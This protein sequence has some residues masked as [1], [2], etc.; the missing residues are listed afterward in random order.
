MH[1]HLAAHPARRPV[2]PPRR[3]ARH[4][5]AR[6]DVHPRRRDRPAG[7]DGRR[8][9]GRGPADG[10]GGGRGRA[11]RGRRPD[12][13]RRALH[14][15]GPGA[16]RLHR[17]GHRARH[18]PRPLAPAEL[19]VRGDGVRR[20][21]DVRRGPGGA[22]RRRGRHAGGR[23]DRHVRPRTAGRGGG[24]VHGGARACGEYHAGGRRRRR[25]SGAPREHRGAECGGRR[26]HEPRPGERERVRGGRGGRPGRAAHRSRTRRRPRRSGRD[27]SRLRGGRHGPV[28]DRRRQRRSRRSDGADH[29]VA[30]P[31]G[32]H[33]CADRGGGAVDVFRRGSAVVHHRRTAGAG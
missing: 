8:P 10:A 15:G 30:H 3:R 4:A 20:P 31:A 14:L 26:W 28:P 22:R 11:R 25:P 12:A 17:V 13:H 33:R 7:A 1:R 18:R 2:A 19:D 23:V 21:D 32:R 24:R 27:R 6:G 29:R 5:G 9:G 16:Q